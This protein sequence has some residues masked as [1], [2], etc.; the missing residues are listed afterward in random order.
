MSIGPKEK[1]DESF[2]VGAGKKAEY[3]V[4]KSI[5]FLWEN[6]IRNIFLISLMAC[7][8]G[9]LFDHKF[10]FEFYIILGILSIVE[11]WKFFNKES[12]IINEIKED[13]K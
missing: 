4:R 13:K 8:G 1:G 7:V 12:V 11:V 10:P 9:L 3:L 5:S 6:P 2:E